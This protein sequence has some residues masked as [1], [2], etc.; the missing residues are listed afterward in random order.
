M[1]THVQAKK[2]NI[3]RYNPSIE[4]G[5]SSEQ[6][7]VRFQEKL[8]N[9]TKAAIGKSYAQIIFD[10]VFSFFNI[11]LFA[12]AG[13]MIWGGYYWGLFFLC[14]LIPNIVIGLYQDIKA[15]VLMGKLRL[16]TQPKATV[17]RDKTK[18]IIETKNLV[19]DDILFL[20]RDAQI[21][22]D[23]ILLDQALIIN[24][25]M[26]T[27]ES[28]D[29]IK[30]PGDT[31][32]SGSYVVSGQ[33]HA[34]VDKVGKNSY[35][36][37][38][39]QSA[40]KFR[41]SPSKI[42]LSLRGLFLV[43]G[44][45]VIIMGALTAVVYWKQ[46]SFQS[47]ESVKESIKYISG[48]M[49]AMIPSGLYLLT[50]VALAVGVIA[51]AKKKAQ[52]Q[53]FYSV[54]MLARTNVLCIDK[55]GTITD[56]SLLVKSFYPLGG[57]D[58]DE[59]AQIVSNVIIA[60]KDDNATAKAL[61][62][63]FTFDLSAGVN[64]VLPFNS[65]NKYSAASFKGGKTYV[66][67]AI[68][69][70]NIVNK[71]AVLSK[72]EEYTSLGYRVLVVGEAS[73]PIKD[74]SVSGIVTP[75]ALIVMQDKIRPNAIQTFK[76]FK[77]NNV[78]IKVISGDSAS[79]TS[80]IARQAGI[81]GAENFISLENMTIENVKQVALYYTVFGR[82][83]PE[84][85][86]A[87]IETLKE[88]KNTVAMTG[89]GVNDILALK[90]A[91]CSIAMA[92]GTDAARNVSHIVLMDSDFSVLPDVVGEGRRV[93]NNLQRTASLFLVKT[94]F[95][96]FFSSAFLLASVIM[97]NELVRYPFIT[98]NMYVWEIISIGIAAFFLSLQKSQGTIQG[99]FMKNILKKAI[100]AAIS[101][102]VPVSAVYLCLVLQMNGIFTGVRP[103]YIAGEYLPTSTSANTMCVL[104]YTLMSFVTL[105]KV[106]SPFD[107][108]RKTVFIALSIIAALFLIGSGL[109]SYLANS[110][111]P[112][113][114]INYLSMS[115]TNYFLAGLFIVFAASF[116]LI[117][118][119]F[120][121]QW[122]EAKKDAKN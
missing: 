63:F 6:V 65:E 93:I 117:S 104:I 12:I 96:F 53:D 32:L 45:L 83:T 113:L 102:I 61:R 105:Y 106:C 103:D 89:D 40:N 70:L 71:K 3:E 95:A 43:I 52:V 79:T 111:D 29:V 44:I 98:N 108:Y 9:K 21:C 38:L 74:S 112:L 22:A 15:R 119:N 82:V 11:V 66:I 100:P 88:N 10:N 56:G 69:F 68:E 1:F 76:W 41:R 91:D 7:D 4:G 62:R 118:T 49:V 109:Y 58:K 101:I 33:A 25:S 2:R 67:G 80:E 30:Q 97:K 81:D 20:S 90:R 18:L 121:H 27:G 54:E 46:G 48:S 36:E 92:S 16:I 23:C 87:I 42:L 122:K 8:N 14:V 39:Q 115:G 26:L 59:I 28:N 19:L 47:M 13:L 57:R 73:S 84:Q 114:Q 77:D 107:K 24:E 120:V 34:R 85:K 60:T 86:E 17:I 51:L 50:S 94:I 116:Y 110:I 55:T 75:L 64:S 35:V 37:G 31:L 5:L 99:S 72:A 78:A